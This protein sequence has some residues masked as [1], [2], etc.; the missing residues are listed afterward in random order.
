MHKLPLLLGY[1]LA[2]VFLSAAPASAQTITGTVT[3]ST[4]GDSLPGVNIAVA[5]TQLGA[6][7]NAQGEYTITGVEPGTYTVRASFIGYGDETEE[8]VTVSAGET[9]EV[10]FTMQTTATDLDEIV[11]VGYGT[12]ERRDLTGSV[13]SVD[14]QEVAET[15]PTISTK[16]LLQGRAAGVQVVQQSG[17]PGGGVNVRVRGLSSITAGN[18]PLYVIDGVPSPANSVSPKNVESI[19]VLKD[20]SATAIYGARGANGVVLITT[21]KGESGRDEVRFQSSYGMQQITRMLPLLN[22]RQFAEVRNEAMVN[23]GLEPAF[24]DEEIASMG[25]GT[26]WQEEIFRP[27]PVQNYSGTV[28]GGDEETSYLISGDFFD[29]QGIIESTDLRRYSARVNLD[30][31]VSDRFRVGSNIF[32]NRT[33]NHSVNTSGAQNG[34]VSE[35]LQFSPTAP[36]RDEEGDFV[37][38]DPFNTGTFNPVSTLDLLN[39]EETTSRL[40]GKFFGEYD[41]TDALRFQSSLGGTAN[42][43]R[44]TYYAPSNSVQGQSSNGEA[45]VN[46]SQS[47]ELVNDNVLTYDQ[48]LGEQSNLEVTAGFTVQTFRSEYVSASAEEFATDVTGA[49]NLGAGAVQG[50]PGSGM[51]EWTLLSYLGRANYTLNDKYLF[52]V[53]GRYDGSSKF[54]AN[55]KWGFFPSGAFGWRISEE[56]FLQEQD[57]I[58]NLKLRVSYGQT[59][60]QDIGTFNSLARLSDGSYALGSSQLVTYAPANRAPNPNLKWETRTQFNLGLDL[61]VWNGRATLTADVYTSITDDLLLSVPLPTTS[62]YRNQLRN[63]G[64]VQNR[65]VELS[66]STTN[67]AQDNLTWT[68]HFNITATRNEVV[69]LAGDEQVFPG[70]QRSS[71]GVGGNYI[72]L[73]EGQPLGAFYG[74]ETDGIWQQDEAAEAAEFD[75]APGEWK[76]VDTNGDGEITPS[77]RTILGTGQADFFGGIGNTFSVGPLTLNVFFQGSYGNEVLNLGSAYNK[78]VTFY[79]NEHAQALDRW[80]PENPSNTVPRANLDRT[81][82]VLE[83]AVEDGSYLRLQNLS[84]GYRLPGEMLPAVRRARIYV[85]G[86]NLWTWTSYTGYDPEVSS[87][88]SNS[89]FRGVDLGMYPRS[90]TLNVGVDLTF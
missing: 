15:T 53:T 74:Y 30:Q 81:R 4:S 60:N 52:T 18:Q 62:G 75:T 77:D 89:R 11:V 2:L 37:L 76:Y 50:N 36:V 83:N 82:R 90:R 38:Y 35:A 45:N 48:S 28:S 67:L 40:A 87:Y 58:S 12:Q 57:L 49:N 17:A 56:P 63:I 10:N 6:A 43:N 29:Q 26:D 46:S 84:L 25:E 20:A 79:A 73:R 8:G 70:N 3:D 13:S 61:G 51:N 78:S 34:L 65:G 64:S 23:A 44:Y 14:V 72:V 9:T 16:Q 86:Q 85:S 19:E 66:I 80:T 68:T 55:E 47:A 27:A 7:T 32:A 71:G 42:F 88:G 69:E 54:G 31:E 39:R 33:Q 59:G 22:A 41:L 21:K 1:A 5:G 24:T